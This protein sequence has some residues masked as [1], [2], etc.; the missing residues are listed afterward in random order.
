MESYILKDEVKICMIRFSNAIM[1]SYYLTN[2]NNYSDALRN[3]YN[4]LVWNYISSFMSEDELQKQG[5]KI[6]QN[7]YYGDDINDTFNDLFANLSDLHRN[8]V[9]K[10]SYDLLQ[11]I[12]KIQHND[13][14]VCAISELYK[15]GIFTD[16][17]I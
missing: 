14:I 7:G 12:L 6:E 17:M 16:D 15:S 10:M 11:D 9:T 1:F 3:K 4:K 5:K 2:Q 13:Y 8:T